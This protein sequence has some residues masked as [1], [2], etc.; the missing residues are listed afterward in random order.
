MCRYDLCSPVSTVSPLALTGSAAKGTHL[1]VLGS[2]AENMAIQ[3]VM[4]VVN[5]IND[6]Y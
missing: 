4:P 2:I 6:I 1:V 5:M 3:N